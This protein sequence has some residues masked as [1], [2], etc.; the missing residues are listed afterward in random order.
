M[1]YTVFKVEIKEW[2]MQDFLMTAYYDG[3][4]V[5]QSETLY[6]DCYGKDIP[7]KSIMAAQAK[8]KQYTGKDW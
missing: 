7:A 3:L 6:K 1:I 2:I 5:E 8:V 4:T